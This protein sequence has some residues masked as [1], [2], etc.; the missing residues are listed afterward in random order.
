LPSRL[1]FDGINRQQI[2]KDFFEL[3]G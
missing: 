3:F 2:E 1:C